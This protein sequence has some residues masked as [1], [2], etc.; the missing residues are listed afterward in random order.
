LFSHF[1]ISIRLL[2][3]EKRKQ[4]IAELDEKI[5][6]LE[7]AEQEIIS[8]CPNCGSIE[9]TVP[10][11]TVDVLGALAVVLDGRIYCKECAYEGLPIIF[12]LE[13]EKDYLRFYEF[14]R[15]KLK[16]FPDISS[17]SPLTH[18]LLDNRSRG[19]SALL[20]NQPVQAVLF[21]TLFFLGF[22]LPLI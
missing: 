21:I 12:D 16:G 9:L 7:A 19:L 13:K 15:V 3:Y 1:R 6:K 4:K 11:T 17:S 22:F 8:A 18:N 14:R 20:F 2:S 10:P 5:I